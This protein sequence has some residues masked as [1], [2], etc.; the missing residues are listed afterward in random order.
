MTP[1]IDKMQEKYRNNLEFKAKGV[2][3]SQ[4]LNFKN[5]Y[6]ASKKTKSKGMSFILGSKQRDGYKKETEILASK[7]LNYTENYKK[8][9]RA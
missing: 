6:V 8:A 5:D 2:R 7:L 3:S 1:I 9:A 4:N